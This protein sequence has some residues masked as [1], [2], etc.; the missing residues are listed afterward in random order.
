MPAGNV[1]AQ[2]APAEQKS[3]GLQYAGSA[4]IRLGSIV[5]AATDGSRSAASISARPMLARLMCTKQV[6][7]G[8]TPVQSGSVESELPESRWTGPESELAGRLPWSSGHRRLHCGLSRITHTRIASLELAPTDP[9]SRVCPSQSA[10]QPHANMQNPH[11]DGLDLVSLDS[12]AARAELLWLSFS[13]ILLIHCAFLDFSGF[14]FQ[15]G[16]SSVLATELVR[17]CKVILRKLEK[18]FFGTTNDSNLQGSLGNDDLQQ[19]IVAWS[20]VNRSLSH[21]VSTIVVLFVAVSN[22]EQPTTRFQPQQ[23]PFRFN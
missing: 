15:S 17:K 12:I 4:P 7:A 9:G 8:L 3:A 2:L 5:G 10:A 19:V 16:L 18:L 1:S 6:P 13:Y 21:V 14:P 23:R 22:R 11:R 20:G